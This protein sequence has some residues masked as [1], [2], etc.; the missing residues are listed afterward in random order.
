M[1]ARLIGCARDERLDELGESV[2]QGAL[3]LAALVNLGPMVGLLGAR[4]LNKFY[5]LDFTEPTL[6]VLM[7]HR[8]VLFGIVGG[9]LT[10]AVFYREL[11]NVAAA[12]GLV[13]ML[14]FVAIA[15]QENHQS[16]KLRRVSI[17]DVVTSIA[18]AAAWA[19]ARI[20]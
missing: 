3:L 1:T 17:I 5:G 9:L 16:P 11:Q 12:I 10:A 18:L 8:A 2:F 7:R 14:S 13:S 4:Q 20:A 6:L 15:A 19:L